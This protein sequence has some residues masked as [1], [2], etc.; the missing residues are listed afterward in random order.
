MN[1]KRTNRAFAKRLKPIQSDKIPHFSHDSFFYLMI[2]EV[3]HENP[4]QPKSCY[5]LVT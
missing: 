1:P 2:L 4:V 5:R 3:Q